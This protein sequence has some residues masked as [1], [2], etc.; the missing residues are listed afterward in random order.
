MN[1]MLGPHFATYK[2]TYYHH[3]QNWL[4]WE[5]QLVAIFTH[6]PFC[7]IVST[8]ME[9]ITPIQMQQ[10]SDGRISQLSK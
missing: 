7:S 5:S 8:Y 9:K 4:F 10:Y 1:L 6:F 2:I 3:A